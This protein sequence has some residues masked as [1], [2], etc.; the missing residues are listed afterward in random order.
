MIY[1]IKKDI[2][3]YHADCLDLMPKLPSKSVD[4][5][6][7]DPPYGTT[8]CKWDAVVPLPEM[9]SAY[10]GVVKP[11]KSLTHFVT[12]QQQFYFALYFQPKKL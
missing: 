1:A 10:A 12:L 2:N 6:L 9:W 7:C 8:A 3:I 4:L 5:V 11:S